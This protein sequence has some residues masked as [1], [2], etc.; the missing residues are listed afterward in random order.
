MGS[1]PTIDQLKVDCNSNRTEHGFRY[2]FMQDETEAEMFVTRLEVEREAVRSRMLKYQRLL[3][4]GR[5]MSPFDVAADDAL[6]CTREGHYK[7][8]LILT[9]LNAVLEVAR[10]ARQE[11]HRH[12]IT[13]ERY[14]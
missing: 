7:D 6:R 13:M 5:W 3:H 4:E 1:T 10:E 12:V 8:G 14:G 11:K 9:A 2:L